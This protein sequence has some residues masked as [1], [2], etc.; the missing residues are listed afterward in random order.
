M[1]EDLK[2]MKPEELQEILK[3]ARNEGA[4]MLYGE[5]I[6]YLLGTLEVFAVKFKPSDV[7]PELFL[8]LVINTLAKVYDEK[9]NKKDD[10]SSKESDS[11]AE[12][13]K[14]PS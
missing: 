14:E 2:P 9:Y 3:K 10:E 4:N 11:K 7:E 13:S 1:S 6:N 12:E 8:G 5:L